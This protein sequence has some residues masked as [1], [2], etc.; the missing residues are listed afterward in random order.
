MLIYQIIESEQLDK[1]VYKKQIEEIKS[2]SFML[3]DVE[4]FEDILIL[5]L[6]KEIIG[7]ILFGIYRIFKFEIKE[8]YQKQGYGRKILESLID[9]KR[10][11]KYEQSVE[12]LH[13]TCINEKLIPF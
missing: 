2:W 10:L 9:Y 6:D 13:L 12:H 11:F 5:R 3:H 1:Q 7:Y 4:T 8:K